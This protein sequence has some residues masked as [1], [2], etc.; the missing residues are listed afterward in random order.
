MKTSVKRLSA[1]LVLFFGLP[2]L[3][4]GGYLKIYDAPASAFIPHLLMVSILVACITGLR[5][6]LHATPL[7]KKLILVINT[8]VVSSTTALLI[9]YYGLVLVGLQSW[10]RVVSTGIIDAYLSQSNEL[11]KALGYSPWAIWSALGFIFALH[12]AATFKYLANYDW[13][14]PFCR[15]ISSATAG[16]SGLTLILIA[17]VSIWELPHRNWGSAGEPISLSLFP[18]RGETAL[19][20]HSINNLRASKIDDAE[21]AVRIAYQPAK[22]DRLSNVVIFVVDALRADHLSLFGYHR[23]TSP[24]LDDLEKSGRLRFKASAVSVCN[25]SS[26]GIRAI[27]S[28]R[29]VDKQANNPMSLQEILQRHGYGVNFILSGDHTNFYGL[30][31]FYRPADSY[32]DSTAQTLRYAND[33]RIITDHLVN[34]PAYDG[35]PAMF[36]FHLMSSHQL[37]K[38]LEGVTEFGESENYSKLGLKNSNPK[39]KQKAIN[40]YDR[41]VLQSDFIIGQALETLKTRGYLDN[42]L[43]VITGDHGETLGEHDYYGHSR[44]VWESGLRVPFVLL[45][46]GKANVDSIPAKTLVSQ[47]DI[48]PTL[49]HELGIP[50]PLTWEGHPVQ[51]ADGPKIVYFQQAHAIGL[52]DARTDGKIY[53]HWNDIKRGEIFTFELLSD[54]EENH[55]LTNTIPESLR[56]EW[57]RLLLSRSASLRQ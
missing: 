36:Q 6:A 28:S 41:G 35:R 56:Q 39:L 20:T 21:E 3:F 11:I 15:T 42:A 45:A 38:R 26:C 24:N 54:P 53:K 43:V 12:W 8:T 1:A 25:E 46:F 4:L 52:T 37:G 27:A 23:S 44:F 29:Y 10:G 9:I 55:N 17:A 57:Q 33:D 5:I 2:V 19:Q 50:I 13:T 7:N 14:S 16:I 32:I 47:V 18:E 22:T 31:D 48:A 49:L 30:R 51:N 34:W 40:F